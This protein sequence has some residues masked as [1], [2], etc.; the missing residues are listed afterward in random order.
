MTPPK[1][2]PQI[3][4]SFELVVVRQDEALLKYV[5]LQPRDRV[6]AV[7]PSAIYTISSCSSSVGVLCSWLLRRRAAR[8]VK[9]FFQENGI[10]I[11]SVI[12]WMTSSNNI[13]DISSH[14]RCSNASLATETL[15]GDRSGMS[16][17]GGGGHGTQTTGS[18]RLAEAGAGRHGMWCLV[19]G[20]NSIVL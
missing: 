3:S 19:F 9:Y 7:T 10:P 11:T 15:P 4:T 20:E 16:P 1:R 5:G 6:T 8:V 2:L 13:Y 14:S 18:G 17:E 12:D